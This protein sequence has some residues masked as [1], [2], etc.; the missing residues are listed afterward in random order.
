[1][2]FW[3]LVDALFLLAGCADLYS[4]KTLR[5]SMGAAFRRPVYVCTAEELCALLHRSGLPLY[6]AALRED[7]LD[8]RAT[9]LSRAAIAIGSEGRG[10]SEAL[11]RCATAR[12]ASPCPPDANR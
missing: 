2:S 9:D 1:M 7:T 6:G 12:C 5:A 3:F 4:P 11:W 10:L 8:A